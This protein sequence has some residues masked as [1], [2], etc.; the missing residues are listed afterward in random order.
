M[1]RLKSRPPCRPQRARSTGA[2]HDRDAPA[3]N[4]LS[5]LRTLSPQNICGGATLPASGQQIAEIAPF[6]IFA[7]DQLYF[8][9]ALPALELFFA[10]NRVFDTVIGLD[11]NKTV[12]AVLLHK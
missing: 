8:P 2:M 12:D 5:S 9:V 6:Q 11:V 1:T 7:L 3:T 4:S 10:G